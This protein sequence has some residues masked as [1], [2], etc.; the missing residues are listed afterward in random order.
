MATGFRDSFVLSESICLW[1]V[2]LDDA[3]GGYCWHGFS[4]GFG[5]GVEWGM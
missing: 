3:W 2:V 5:A 4:S 1:M